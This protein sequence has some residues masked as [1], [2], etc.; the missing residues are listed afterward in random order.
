MNKT[1]F[2][3]GTSSGFGREVTKLFHQQGWNVI[4]TM[5]NPEKETELQQLDNVL[6]TKL[7]V[8]DPATITQAV[9]EGL[10]RFGNIDVLVNNA[11]Y[12]V[13]GAFE[14][15]THEQLLQ[16]YNVNVFGLM[17]V[18]RAILPYLRA[19]G[20]G[21]IINLS[22]IGGI[23]G[24]PFGSPYVSSKFAVEGF[25]ESL[26]HELKPLNIGVK[27]IE[28]G[29][30]DTNF[31]NSVQLIKNEIV[32]YNEYFATFM[33]NLSTLTAPMKPTTAA[34]VAQLIYEAATDN[35]DQLRY[36]IGEDAHYYINNKNNHQLPWQ[37]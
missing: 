19:Q 28:P 15:S 6:V 21:T 10:Q 33:T 37:S 18:T 32:A 4:A 34:D 8:K 13:M 11:G 31:R 14:S 27:L 3:T 29:S 36:M 9:N 24:F 30:V 7:D 26:H 35:T 16:M 23:F 22:S 12:S 2:I 1:I 5:R 25:S 20:H 17:D